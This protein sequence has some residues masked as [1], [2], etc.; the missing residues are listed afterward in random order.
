MFQWYGW[1]DLQ[2]NIGYKRECDWERNKNDS[3]NSIWE[4]GIMFKQVE[5]VE[6]YMED[7]EL[8]FRHVKFEIAIRY[9]GGD[10]G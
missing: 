5:C 6:W 4:T 10:S 3:N 2:S 9:P 8:G 1:R 7:Q